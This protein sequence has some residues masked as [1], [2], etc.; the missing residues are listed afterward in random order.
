MRFVLSLMMTGLLL[1][2][3]SAPP[4]RAGDE[5]ADSLELAQKAT[6]VLDQVRR[7]PERSIPL[8]LLRNAKAV[9]V[10][11]TVIKAGFVFGGSH[12]EALVSRRMDDGSWSYPVFSDITGGSVGLQIG[13]S[14]TDVVLVFRTE[15]GVERLVNG[16]FTLGANAAVAAG[17]VGRNAQASTD[18]QLEADILSYSRARGLFAGV[19]LDGTSMTI[20]YD[21]NAAIY[22]AGITPR[23]IFDGGVQ[24]VPEP[25]TAFRD[26]LERYTQGKSAPSPARSTSGGER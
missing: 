21:D 18:A 22:G 5:R 1:A 24:N 2:V 26:R 8:D 25:I 23:R 10:A 12:G 9:A 16:K 14:S 3:M 13:A 6:R 7:S 15:D 19:S 4:A 20:D 11:P 17:P